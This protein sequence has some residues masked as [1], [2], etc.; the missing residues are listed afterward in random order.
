M[1]LEVRPWIGAVLR[2]DSSTVASRARYRDGK[3]DYSEY[4]AKV[5]KLIE[6]AVVADGIQLLVKEVSLFSKDFE[7]KVDSLR[8]DEAKAS[9]MEHAI[10]HEIHVHFEQNPAFYQGLRDR[11]EQIIADRKAKRIDAAEQLS[12]EMAL[13]ADLHGGAT[14]SA[15]DLD[16]TESGFAIYGLLE[17]ARPTADDDADEDG[18]SPNRDL[19]SLI[20]DAIAP[21]TTLVDWHTKDDIQRNIRKAVK[22]L[23]RAAGVGNVDAVAGRLVD[24]AKARRT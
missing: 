9:E 6:D 24:L 3:P 23:L 12:L 2:T 14:E 15:Q 20:D 5:R 8:S 18:Y 19:A 21:F 22:R 4:G 1:P 11:L 13:R 7:A 16:L 17:Q 10:R